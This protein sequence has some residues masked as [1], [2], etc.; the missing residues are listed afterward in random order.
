VEYD[1]KGPGIGLFGGTATDKPYD[2][3]SGEKAQ[4][5][6]RH[7]GD[8]YFEGK[9]GVGTSTPTRKF[10]VN[11]GTSDTSARFE[12]SQNQSLIIMRNNVAGASTQVG[13]SGSDFIV[14]TNGIEKMRILADG[15]IGVGTSTPTRKFTVNGGS[16]DTSAQFE[17]DQSQSLI[18]MRN[19]VAGASTQIGLDG[20]DF[21]LNVTG[22][23]RLRVLAD[24]KVGIGTSVPTRKFTVN[25]GT[26][27]TSA[28]FESTQ[29]QSLIIMRNSVAGAST[30]VGLDGSDF[31]LNINGLEKFRVKLDGNVGIATSS[32]TE[33][34]E[35]NGNAKVSG[36][37]QLGTV[38]GQP[39]AG[40]CSAS[41]YGR[42]KVDPTSGLMWVCVASGWLSK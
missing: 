14:N 11:G 17:S 42:M 38:S 39:P 21:R 23:E 41:V 25:G 16:S 6:L 28:Q 4:L 37:I 9:L 5:V 2:G 12:S 1:N 19:N 15:K 32:P 27:D 35:V 40:D 33:K 7:D 31:I 20:S 26:S 34:L 3:T 10:S 24:G 36:Y 8:S 18:I 13:L 30:Q 22:T 29:T